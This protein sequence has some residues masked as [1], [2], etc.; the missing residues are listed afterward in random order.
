M[1]FFSW[2]TGESWQTVADE[3]SGLFKAEIGFAEFRQHPIVQDIGALKTL[4]TILTGLLLTLI[5]IH[6]A[7]FT[8]VTWTDVHTCTSLT[9]FSKCVYSTHIHVC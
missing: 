8:L 9:I 7:M 4:A 6:L 5:F 2:L 3:A 1:F